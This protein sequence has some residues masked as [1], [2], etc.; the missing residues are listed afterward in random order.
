M[1][2]GRFVDARILIVDDEEGIVDVLEGFLRRQGYTHLKATTDPRHALSLFSH[3]QPDLILL[4]LM[5]PHLDG[6]AVMQQV[7]A[8]VPEGAYLPILII[9]ADISPEAR[10]Q[11]LSMGAKDFLTKPFDYTDVRL[12]V[13]N[14]LEA[15]FL[16]RQ[17]EKQDQLVEEKVRERTQSLEKERAEILERLAL[18]AEFREDTTGQH[19]QRVG[20]IATRLAEALGLPE[21][22]V[23][24]I[25]LAAP[26]H[27]VGKIGIPDHILRKP[28]RLS[29]G[30]FETVKTHTTIGAKILLGCRSPLLQAA[31]E[32]ALTHHEHWDGSGY[33]GLKGE[34]IPL[35][36]RI[37]ALADVYEALT[38]DRP[39]RKASSVDEAVNLI[40]RG[41]G[42]YF[43]P[44]V[45][46]AFLRLV[47]EGLV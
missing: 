44:R 38:N 1:Q 45:V 32:I 20:H 3:F 31:E 36:G 33:A 43:D 13:R 4:D 12:R 19:A 35:A 37:V 34:A 24:Q 6:F 5:M 9:T 28:G 27:D 26:L 30:E 18:I 17:I 46:S 29:L 41:G 14:L 25:R 11:A 7:K 2:D 15:R 16:H 22:Q 42:R 39:Y 21:A 10:H 40:E 47:R 8:R 23:E